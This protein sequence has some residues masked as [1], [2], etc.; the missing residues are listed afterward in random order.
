MPCY[1]YPFV[2]FKNRGPCPCIPVRFINPDT[3]E[4]IVMSCLLDSGAAASLL[5]GHVPACTGH[6]LKGDRVIRSYTQG[7]EGTELTI[8]MHTFEIELLHPDDDEEVV[9]SAKEILIGC[10][11]HKLFPPLLGREDFF[12]HFK[13]TFDRRNKLTTLS[14]GQS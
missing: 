5:P 8:Y 13:V 7:I 6:D 12:C 11:E 1:V 10:S 4:H 2:E 9:W 3:G 14:W